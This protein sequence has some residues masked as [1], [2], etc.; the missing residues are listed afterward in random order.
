MQKKLISIIV[1]AYNEEECIDKFYNTVSEIIN[2][3]PKYDFEVIIAENGSA[4]STFEK[5]IEINKKDPRFKTVKLTRNCKADGGIDAAIKYAKGDA[6]IITY[7]DMEDPPHLFAKFIEQWEN[8]YQH[9]YGITRRRQGGF[10]RNF[11]SKIFYFLINKLTGNVVPRNVSDFRLVDKQVYQEFNKITE[12]N[13][14]LRG[15]FA[16]LNYK[17][18]GIEYDRV[19]RAGGKSKANTLLALSIAFKSIFSYSVFPLR[20]ASLMGL[21][22]SALS[23]AG[24]MFF[25]VEYLLFGKFPPFAGFGT[26]VC[27][28]LLLFGILFFLIGLLGE[29]IGLIYEEVKGRPLYVIEKTVGIE[30]NNNSN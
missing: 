2:K 7:S 4:D 15:L 24:I 19:P 25:V 5:L 10:I 16:W 11:N 13:K 26:L 8:G 1:P 3:I 22:V 23:F 27:L 9:V 18:I 28:I 6:A 20:I 29:Y 17:S 14:F 12:K 21:I 30:K